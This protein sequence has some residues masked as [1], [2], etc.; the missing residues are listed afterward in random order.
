MLFHTPAV[1]VPL[2]SFIP[3]SLYHLH[4]TAISDC[5]NYFGVIWSLWCLCGLLVFQFLCFLGKCLQWETLEYFTIFSAP[6]Y[7]PLGNT[8]FLALLK[9]RMI[10]RQYYYWSFFLLCFFFFP[11]LY[12]S[13]TTWEISLKVYFGIDY[14]CFSF[15]PFYFFN[16]IKMQDGDS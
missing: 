4:S 11:P 12:F 1:I 7:L 15:L 6:G 3:V 16:L 5:L 8:C 9:T 14:I 10:S 2:E 13:C